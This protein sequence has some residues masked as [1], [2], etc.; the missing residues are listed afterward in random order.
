MSDIRG[1]AKGAIR[2]FGDLIVWQKAFELGL[3]VFAAS[4]S[5]PKEEKYVLTD[6]VRR[7]SRS[8]GANM[9]EAWASDVTKRTLSASFPMRMRSCMRRNMG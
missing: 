4:K 7:S 3:Q 8:V 9:A 1:Q 5:W 6:Q 2:H